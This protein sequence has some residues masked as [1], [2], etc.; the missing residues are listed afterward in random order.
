MQLGMIGLGRMGANMV[1]RLRLGGHDIAAF[2]RNPQA[3]AASAAT[4]ARGCSSLSELVKALAPPRN[5]W[6]ML[7]A[8]PATNGTIDELSGLLGRGDVIV[9]GGNSYWKEAQ[10]HAKQ[11]ASKNITFIDAGVS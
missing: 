1:E 5:V 4:G 2:D 6:I 8:G 10:A 11:L 9:D 7:P 3:V